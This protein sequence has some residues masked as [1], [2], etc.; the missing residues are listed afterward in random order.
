MTADETLRD[1]LIR[2][3]REIEARGIERG[4]Q[5]VQDRQ[6]EGQLLRDGSG[7]VHGVVDGVGLGLFAHG[8]QFGAEAADDLGEGGGFVAQMHGVTV[9]AEPYSWVDKLC[10]DL[11]DIVVDKAPRWFLIGCCALV[12]VGAPFWIAESLS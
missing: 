2:V 9:P 5:V 7:E 1:R 3:G 6:R 10:D 8:D 4:Q 11:L 12:A